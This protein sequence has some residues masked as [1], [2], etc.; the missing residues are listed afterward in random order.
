MALTAVT[1]PGRRVAPHTSPRG[2]DT[3]AVARFSDDDTTG[4]GAP[5]LPL[6][7]AASTLRARAARH[8]LALCDAPPVD[9]AAAVVAA[10]AWT[11]ALGATA[12]DQP[13]RFGLSAAEA[14]SRVLV[15]AAGSAKDAAADPADLRAAAAAPGVLPEQWL[16]AAA[17]WDEWLEELGL[18]PGQV[19]ARVVCDLVTGDE[20]LGGVVALLLADLPEQ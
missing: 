2:G 8:G 9:L 16:Q 3:V 14:L 7:R 10:D 15:R 20:R 12:L 18:D 1:V 6:E 5:W 4:F 19:F 13:M 17:L 11:V